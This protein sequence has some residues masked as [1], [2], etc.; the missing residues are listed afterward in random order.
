MDK[1]KFIESG[2]IEQYVLGIVSP[3]ERRDIE[4]LLT[5]H[6]DLRQMVEELSQ[7]LESYAKAHTTPP[8]SHLRQKVLEAMKAVD[9]PRSAPTSPPPPPAPVVQRS[10]WS[11]W[12]TAIAAVMVLGLSMVCML[13]Y[14]KQSEAQQQIAVLSSQVEAL[15]RDYQT[16]QRV[17]KRLQ[18]QFAILKDV[19]T[20][21]VQLQ[22]SDL[23]PS[24]KAVVYW[25]ENHQDAYLN[26][27]DMPE[28]PHG[29]QYQVWADVNGKHLDMGLLEAQADPETGVALF[30]LPYIEHSRGFVITLE[31]SGGS[32]HPTV[33]KLFV[34]GNL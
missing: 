8:P 34:K 13:M 25:N 19:S 3:E 24:A 1:Q 17:D 30:K 15:Q 16:L 27:V 9:V 33:E 7:G 11:R 22:G 23:A 4:R 10:F 5:R 2:L 12:G 26:V 20:R 14:S 31:K 6:P 29:H 28:A 32:P 18:T 21:H